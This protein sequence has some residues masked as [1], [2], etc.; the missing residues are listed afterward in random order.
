MINGTWEGFNISVVY[1]IAFGKSFCTIG[2]MICGKMLDAR[3][4]KRHPKAKQTLEESL[5]GQGGMR[6]GGMAK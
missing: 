5:P 2:V 3:K 1:Q 4:L 6:K